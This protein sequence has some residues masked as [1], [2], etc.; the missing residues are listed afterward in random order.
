MITGDYIEKD[1]V[2]K[3][4]KFVKEKI[5]TSTT[6]IEYAIGGR[7]GAGGVAKVYK[8]RR[9]SDKAEFV[10]KNTFPLPDRGLCIVP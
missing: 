6:G 3:S 7:L 10:L 2:T 1:R 8:A 9:L 4:G 5:V